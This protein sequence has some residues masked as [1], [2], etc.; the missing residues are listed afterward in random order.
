[1]GE[2]EAT[3]MREDILRTIREKSELQQRVYDNTFNVFTQ[4]KDVLHEMSSELNDELEDIDRRVKI[5]YRDRGKFEAQLQVAAD[6]LIFSMHT[7]VFEFNREHPIW[8]N[9]YVARDKSNSYCGII[10]I[11]NFL[12][13]SF[14]YNRNSDEGYLIGRIFVNREMQYFVEGKRQISMRHNNF[15]TQR[16][17]R[18]ALLNIVETAID[19]TI[20]FDLLVPPYDAVKIVSV[21]QLNTKIENSKIQTGKRL[22]YKFCSDD[23]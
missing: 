7:N 12:S 5:E 2:S 23:I 18:D 16:I 6:T 9:S 8:Q 14:R 15:G 19:Y 3:N 10:N 13:D 4:L 21:D 20:D 1:M 11:Y 17:D 22:G